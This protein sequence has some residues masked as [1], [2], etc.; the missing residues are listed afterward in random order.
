ME[1]PLE[2]LE[3]ATLARWPPKKRLFPCEPGFYRTLGFWVT[4]VSIYIYHCLS[5]MLYLQVYGVFYGVEQLVGRSR[6]I[7]WP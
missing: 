7:S 6:P 1:I 3:I 5:Y 2:S 4:L